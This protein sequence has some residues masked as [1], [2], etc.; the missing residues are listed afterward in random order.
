LPPDARKLP[1]HDGLRGRPAA[2]EKRPT[3][4]LPRR[5]PLPTLFVFWNRTNER[6]NLSI[7][8]LQTKRERN[9]KPGNFLFNFP[10]GRFEFQV[11]PSVGLGLDTDMKVSLA[12]ACPPVACLACYLLLHCYLL[13]ARLLFNPSAWLRGTVMPPHSST[14][15]CVSTDQTCLKG[16]KKKKK[17]KETDSCR[18]FRGRMYGTPQSS[19]HLSSALQS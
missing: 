8:Y 17:R 1:T 19:Q 2:P 7:F 18:R 15:A 16:E 14:P 9:Q 10:G 12:G 13:F 11:V 3:R 6:N 5:K 4:L